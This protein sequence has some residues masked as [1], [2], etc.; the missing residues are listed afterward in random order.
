M[1][2]ARAARTIADTCRAHELIPP[3]FRSPPTTPGLD[4][5][6][7]RS[8][9]AATISV[10]LRSRPFAAVLADMVE[11]TVTANGLAG[12]TASQ[13]RALLWS[14]LGEAAVPDAA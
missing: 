2:F 4:R 13:V 14:A 10:R 7:K 8:A 3:S 12:E 1:R 5:T 11:G 6:L 9:G